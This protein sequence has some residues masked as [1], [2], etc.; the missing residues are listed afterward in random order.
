MK[1]YLIMVLAI[2]TSGVFVGCHEEEFGG[3]V[4]EQKKLA[5]EDAFIRAFGQPDPNHNWGFKISDA[6]RG[7][8]RSGNTAGDYTP[9]PSTHQ[10][11]DANGKLIA[12]A[13]MNHNQWGSSDLQSMPFGGWIVPDPLTEG[14]KLRVQKY[15][16]AN[17][18]LSYQ[19][20]Y[21]ANFYVQQ[22]YTGGTDA[23][24][25]GNKE[26]TAG[27]NGETHKGMTLN[28]L[29]VGAAG[30]HINDF[31]AGTCT[32][33]QVLNHEGKTQND[34]ITLMLNVDDTSCFG[35]H[36]TSGSNVQASTNHNDKMALVSAATIDAWA[37]QNGNPG[38]A[39]VD[40]WNRSFMGFDYELL[41]ESDIVTDN[42]ARLDAVPNLNNIPYAWDGQKVMIIGVAPEATQAEEKD[43]TSTFAQNVSGQNVTCSYDNNGNI[44]CVFA[45]QY[46]NAITFKQSEDFSPYD[47]LKIEFA[48]PSPF[49]ATLSCNGDAQISEGATEV[50]VATVN[51]AYN[52]NGGPT[53]S[54]GGIGTES[55]TL[56]IKKVTLMKEATAP[57]PSIVYYNPTYLLGDNDADKIA[58]YST[59]TNMYGGTILN[60]TEDE[61][62]T[63]QDGK[64]CLNLVKFQQLKN[65][66]YHPITTD[67]KT[68]VKWQAACDGYYSD[69]IVTLTEAKRIDDIYPSAPY[70]K[71][72]TGEPGK[73]YTKTGWTIVESGRVMCEDLATSKSLD[74]MDFNDV[75]YDAI[76]FKEYKYLCTEDGTLLSDDS[77]TDGYETTYANVRLM[78]AGGTIPVEMV[79]GENNYDVHQE[80][81]APDNVMINTLPNTEKDRKEVN[82]ATV[83]ES[84]SA[85]TLKDKKTG[86]EKLYGVSSISDIE[87]NVLYNN[88]SAKLSSKDVYGAATYMFCVDLNLPWARERTNFA[89]PYPS[90]PAWVK[91]SKNT[92]W[93][94][95][96]N[97]KYFYT[98]N[99]L[100]GLTEP[101][102]PAPTIEFYDNNGAGSTLEKI[103]TSA[104]PGTMA[105][106]DAST[107]NIL[108]D[109]DAVGYGPGF[110]CPAVTTKDGVSHHE[111]NVILTGT[112]NITT[113]NIVRIYGVYI[114]NWYINTN[115]SGMINS[116]AENGYIEIKINSNNVSRIQN[117]IT[118]T[119][120][121]FT[122]TYVTVL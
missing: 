52:G 100:V 51:Y 112:S 22:V 10:Y 21:Y 64:T 15:F 54:N 92:Q 96:H 43:I 31:N 17:P 46:Y 4:I 85:K 32:T 118:I 113:G 95:D 102:I 12:S 63:T 69:W 70:V 97:S 121:N 11:Y 40:K 36:E 76:I 25:T 13:N 110:L 91:N 29:T 109:F 7:I 103:T 98:N 37:A 77:F 18:N 20:P 81:G 104:N 66:G 57:D 116:G 80:L 55:K 48:E 23:P 101:T 42:Y 115:F 56:K 107:E 119:G 67:L 99:N 94:K 26:A 3:S 114:N 38:E 14:Q 120:Q 35:F 88:V 6:T 33:S 27:A 93:Y 2:A 1:K 9:W 78:A 62:K 108:F 16:Q 30:S 49:A 82:M 117:G 53:I 87:L 65:D 105:Y 122:V 72:I 111:E 73:R 24:T 50:E 41:P 47:K 83:Y 86:S 28:Q 8:T 74:D 44:V 39:V 75:V 89:D 34:Q 19:D 5:F 90:F 58:F 71:T 60:L 84:T 68:W 106:P 45:G 59:N 79:V 61:M